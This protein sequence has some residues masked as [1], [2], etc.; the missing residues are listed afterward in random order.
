MA[1]AF[2]ASTF[3][4]YDIAEDAVKRAR[5][6]AD[7]EGLTNARFEVR[8]AATLTVAERLDAV[9]TLDAIHDQV[10]PVA[11]LDRIHAALAPGGTYLM[12]EPAASS[13][14]EDNT[15]NPLA[16]WIYGVSTLHC[17][18]VSLAHGGAGLGTAWGEQRARQMLADAGFVDV[19]IHDAPGD[20]LDSIYVATE[21]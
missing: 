7:A 17:M 4:G 16:P 3:V 6:E 18:T 21:G 19:T 8:D 20:P 11:V 1:K 15:A 14:L 9:I 13:N 12:V 2:P 10:D 5:T